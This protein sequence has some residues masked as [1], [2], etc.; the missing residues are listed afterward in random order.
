MDLRW[1]CSLEQAL[2]VW[3]LRARTAWVRCDGSKTYHEGKKLRRVVVVVVVV[4][5]IAM[6]LGPT[7]LREC[8]CV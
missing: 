4:V 1:L 6:H 7:R 3:L 8:E 2:R 5:A